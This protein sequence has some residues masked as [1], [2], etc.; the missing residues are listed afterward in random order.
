MG[1]PFYQSRV[2]SNINTQVPIDIRS[3]LDQQTQNLSEIK[4]LIL[5]YKKTQERKTHRSRRLWR[6]FT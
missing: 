1:G 4:E 3:R 6:H 2:H 5:Q